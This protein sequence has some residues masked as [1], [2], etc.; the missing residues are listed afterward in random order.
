MHPL[1]DAATVGHLYKQGGGEALRDL[2][3]GA[4]AIQGAGPKG[5]AIQVLQS[6]GEQVIPGA[7]HPHEGNLSCC[8]AYQ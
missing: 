4:R 3:R 8:A 5:E 7:D 2:P 6:Q 1:D